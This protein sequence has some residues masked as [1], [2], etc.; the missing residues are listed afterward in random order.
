MGSM[1]PLEE[2]ARLALRSVIDPE[3]GLDVVALGLVYGID[4]SADGEL[5]VKLTMTTPACPLGQQ[6]AEDAERSLRAL[7]GVRS[8]RV[9]LVWE[10]AWTPERMSS[11]ARRALGWGG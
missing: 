5:D 8:A 11:D 9:E 1:S 2:S 4:V 10:P 3:L 6:I 7:S